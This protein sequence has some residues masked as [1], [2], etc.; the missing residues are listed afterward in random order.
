MQPAT[1]HTPY[2]SGRPLTQVMSS[3]LVHSEVNLIKPC[4]I[5]PCLPL[6]PNHFS[7]AAEV[8]QGVR[9]MLLGRSEA[10]SHLEE[11]APVVLPHLPVGWSEGG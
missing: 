3:R 11:H 7:S 10:C 4:K 9:H 1:H 6:P 2:G 5:V 8:I